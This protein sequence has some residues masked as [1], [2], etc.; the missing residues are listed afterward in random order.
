[1]CT[2]IRKIEAGKPRRSQE[3]GSYHRGRRGGGPGALR[4]RPDAPAA[5]NHRGVPRCGDGPLRRGVHQRGAP[6]LQGDEGSRGTMQIYAKTQ[7]TNI[8]GNAIPALGMKPK[9]G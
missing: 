8:S 5:Q 2:V 6:K 7:G 9:W 4:G 3:S 1:M